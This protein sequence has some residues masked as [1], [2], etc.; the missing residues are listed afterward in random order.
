MAIIL[1]EQRDVGPVD[2]DIRF[3]RTPGFFSRC[4]TRLLKLSCLFRKVIVKRVVI[5][6]FYLFNFNTF[7][8]GEI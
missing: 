7:Q 8:G 1:K 2:R 6:Y 4:I 3:Y 5:H